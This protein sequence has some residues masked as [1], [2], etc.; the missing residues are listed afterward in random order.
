MQLELL[1]DTV[2]IT[3]HIV[4]IVALPIAGSIDFEIITHPNKHDLEGISAWSPDDVVAVEH[5]KRAL[6]AASIFDEVLYR[7]Y[8]GDGEGEEENGADEGRSGDGGDDGTSGN[9]NDDGDADDTQIASN[10]PRQDC[11]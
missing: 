8:G 5:C 4:S 6:G 7:R 3:L 11:I 10:S 2:G 1:S 9:D